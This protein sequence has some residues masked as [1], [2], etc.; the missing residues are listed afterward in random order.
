MTYQRGITLQIVKKQGKDIIRVEITAEMIQTSSLSEQLILKGRGKDYNPHNLDEPDRWYNGVMGEL[1]FDDTL[2]NLGKRYEY[3]V[4]DES[5][6]PDI[7]DFIVY[8]RDGKRAII[9]VKT[10]SQAHHKEMLVPNT[11]E[12]HEIYVAVRL[13]ADADKRK[14]AS[15]AEIW[16][17][18]KQDELVD[19]NNPN[20]KVKAKGKLLKDL[21]PI[22]SLL[23]YLA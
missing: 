19:I 18:C 4:A 23:D 21:R 9:D 14:L 22:T 6:K 13:N 12:H 20:H 17:W 11:Q 7:G 5:G 10:A 2:Y 3:I 16:G 1:A 15:H 8:N